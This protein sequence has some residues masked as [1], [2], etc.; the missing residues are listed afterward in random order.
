[1]LGRKLLAEKHC[2]ETCDGLQ[3]RAEAVGTGV[4]APLNTVH[5]RFRG[6]FIEAFK[7]CPGLCKGN[8]NE[9]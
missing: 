3:T 8:L 6:V 9:V 1:M 7:I 5:V 4:F 2:L